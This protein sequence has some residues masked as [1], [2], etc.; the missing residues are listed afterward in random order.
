MFPAFVSLF[1]PLAEVPSIFFLP[2]GI[3]VLD[4]SRTLLL[5][6]TGIAL[7]LTGNAQVASWTQRATLLFL[8]WTVLSSLV[9]AAPIDSLL[10]CFTW[11]AAAAAYS[12]ART[13][14]PA[15][16]R[17][18]HR[19][20]LLHGLV[21]IVVLKGLYDLLADPV[22][23]K[24]VGP[25]QLPNVYAN[26]LLLL[27]P[28]VLLDLL[29]EDHRC[30]AVALATAP[31]M[32]TS[33]WLTMSRSTWLLT[34][35]TL[36]ATVLLLTRASVKRILIYSLAVLGAGLVLF[37]LRES[38]G[39]VGTVVSLMLLLALP[40]SV[41]S[42]KAG[43]LFTL[44]LLVLI[45]LSILLHLT[46]GRLDSQKN[47]LTD[48][49]VRMENLVAGD[50]STQTRLELWTAAA[51][52]TLTHPL[53]GSGPNSFSEYYPQFQKSFHRYSDSPHS[54]VLELGSEV[55]LVGAGLFLLALAA[56][57]TE[58]ARPIGA[59]DT[60]RSTALLG[61]AI[62]ALQAQIDVTYQYSEIWLS[63]ALVLAVAAG[64]SGPPPKLRTGRVAL[65]LLAGLVL[66]IL[67]YEQRT[68]ENVRN[69]DSQETVYRRTLLITE[70]V[71]GWSK[72]ILRSLEAGLY[73][74][75]FEAEEH[76]TAELTR[77]LLSLSAKA[78]RWA[79]HNPR[80]YALSGKLS[81]LSGNPE[82][83][84]HLFQQS[85]SI[86]PYNFPSAYE[87]LLLSAVRSG[88]AD[89]AEQTAEKIVALYEPEKLALAHTGHKLTLTRQLIPLFFHL[90][91]YMN[92]YEQPEKLENIMR[93][94]VQEAPGPRSFYG[95]GA[96]LWA[97]GKQQ[98]GRRYFEMAHR[99]D[100]TFPSPP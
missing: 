40:A 46:I 7:L 97:Q 17:T 94:L 66:S 14:Q 23:A 78:Q 84:E 55:G 85:L 35:F 50:N 25:F 48:A 19:I 96:A 88:H 43:R 90:A 2:T 68:F 95:L 4:S 33:L 61:A 29:G 15:E 28:M 16:W 81:L 70:R 26:W 92:P 93:F 83:A 76:D 31:I 36:S 52:I 24:T 75:E 18:E 13:L 9:G 38:L 77:Q 8:G 37:L 56:W 6:Y 42:L 27:L 100:P 91:D 86:D 73:L 65:A 87:G 74:L 45:L 99:A 21:S 57:W 5:L 82:K 10:F 39:G 51:S 49:G 3:G 44:K 11:F 34:S 80:T 32:V 12:G 71:P 64:P 1:Q 79:S 20:I 98:E 53:F 89:V 47:L 69:Q 60:A 59:K 30:S 58:E 41:E 72:P 54:A 63:L 67:V 22:A 62:A